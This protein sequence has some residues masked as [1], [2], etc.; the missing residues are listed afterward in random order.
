MTMSIVIQIEQN[1]RLF[2][3]LTRESGLHEEA[4]DMSPINHSEIKRLNE[5]LNAA[6]RAADDLKRQQLARD[7]AREA[8]AQQAEI[9]RRRIEVESC[10]A[11]VHL[12][13]QLAISRHHNA[14]KGR[15]I[16][17]LQKDNENLDAALKASESSLAEL[18]HELHVV[19]NSRSM[20]ITKPLRDLIVFVQRMKG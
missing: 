2:S 8:Q 19:M 20:A 3:S 17:Q 14:E 1:G 15:L 9:V 7:E 11:E 10:K 13:E 18:R 4:K 5:A 6:I 16:E 12:A